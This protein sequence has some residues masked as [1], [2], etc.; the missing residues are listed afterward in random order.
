M[1]DYEEL[2]AIRE[3]MKQ[4]LRAAEEKAEELRR[5]IRDFDRGGI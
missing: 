5:R 4:E 1:K 3:A 2:N